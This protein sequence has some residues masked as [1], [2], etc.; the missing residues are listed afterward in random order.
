MY[1]III[2]LFCVSIKSVK[3]LKICHSDFKEAMYNSVYYLAS[4][5]SNISVDIQSVTQ[6]QM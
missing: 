5:H 3:L 1:L 2:L 6:K 4:F